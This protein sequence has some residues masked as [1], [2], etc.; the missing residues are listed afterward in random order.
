[1]ALNKLLSQ[2]QQ[3]I[4]VGVFLLLTI[5]L[6]N[7]SEDPLKINP[8]VLPDDQ[9][10]DAIIDTLPVELFTIGT[11]AL[12]T[13]S[14]TTVLLGSVNDTVMG[15]LETDFLADFIYT[16]EPTFKDQ[17]DLDS[18]SIIDLYIDLIYATQ[19]V[20][21]SLD[22][23]EVKV[24]ELLEPMPQYTKS[25][26]LLL[27]HM[28]DPEALNIDQ[29]FIQRNVNLTEFDYLFDTCR[30]LLNNDYAQ[31]FLDT[32]LINQEIYHSNNQRRFKEN[33]K[34][35]YFTV[36][37]LTDE[38]GGIISMSQPLV[39]SQQYYSSLSMTLRTLEWIEDS[40]EWDTIYNYFTIGY[41][42]SA[43]DTGGV[44]LSLYRNTQ[45]SRVAT[46]FNDTVNLFP[47]AYIQSLTG[48]Q[49]FVK[50]PTLPE[51]RNSLETSVSVIQAQLILPIEMGSYSRD[52]ERYF[53][54]SR[55]GLLD[56]VSKEPL[57]DDQWA[58]NHLWGYI[59][60]TYSESHRYVLNIGNHVNY[61]IQEE[62]LGL[63]NSFYL[64]AA[65]LNTETTVQ[66]LSDKPAR[67][68]LNGNTNNYKPFV[69]IIYSKIP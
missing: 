49:V 57:F 14:M 16:V 61:Y 53:P 34:G 64:F 40:A 45:S 35:F 1:M 7:C 25:D 37:P 36:Q 56:G 11:D 67:V 50:L 13:Q 19:N 42:Q 3:L 10:L 44:H 48:P 58:Q 9:M 28:Y 18:V 38:G 27:P 63:S 43:I 66:Y 20:Y 60:T 5:T 54:P 22:D 62:S 12:E 6:S 30:I 4:R 69:R 59:D 23:Y 29:E 47:G 51:F 46:A 21:G 41:P 26:Y 24:Y 52:I 17:T 8:G 32:A 2:L 31:R 65:S 39:Y 68:V 15:V 33:F 55:L